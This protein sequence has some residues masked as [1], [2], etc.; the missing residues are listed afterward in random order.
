MAERKIVLNVGFKVDESELK[1]TFEKYE[2]LSIGGGKK[3][4][5]S[6]SSVGS[7][8][9][10]G[11]IGGLT[12]FFLGIGMD[13]WGKVFSGIY[14]SMQGVFM[15]LE[16][17]GK[18]V[19]MIAMPFVN[20]LIPLLLPLLVP[21]TN[22]AK[23]LNLLL[24]PLYEEL[25]GMAKEEGMGIYGQGLGGGIMGT[26]NQA[27]V[28][29][30]LKGLGIGGT[31]GGGDMSPVMNAIDGY[32]GGITAWWDEATADAPA[33][34]EAAYSSVN[35]YIDGIKGFWSEKL[36]ELGTP[37]S[38]A[39]T[40]VSNFFSGITGWFVEKWNGAQELLGSIWTQIST[41]FG[42]LIGWF[43]GKWASIQTNYLEPI[44]SL[45]TSLF[46]GIKG[47]I[48]EQLET[49]GINAPKPASSSGNAASQAFDP[50]QIAMGAISLMSGG[51]FKLPFA[52][53]GG[54]VAETGMAVIHKGETITPA[55]G[56]NIEVNMP[57]NA[58]GRRGLT[59]AEIDQ[60]MRL[61]SVK[62]QTLKHGAGGFA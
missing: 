35:S 32:I 41:L 56:G 22:V 10:S 61:V 51:G 55:G 48:E 11:I 23:M 19:G 8:L 53:E 26:I 12:G 15:V 20:L 62:L 38:E 29:L 50:F 4:K 42:G 54:T 2:K 21:L 52:Q 58:G 5:K 25:M 57:I 40:E 46:G 6:D 14:D 60:I 30:V 39:W 3:G 28:N 49:F 17:I 13:A 47:W 16:T 33:K 59:Q 44:S 43:A 1:K 37:Q 45:F 9:A 18:L 36:I 34:N 24:R 7:N 27:L 31:E